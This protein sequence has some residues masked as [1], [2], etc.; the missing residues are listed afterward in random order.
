M[1]K[2]HRA[3]GR[4]DGKAQ[5]FKAERVADSVCGFSHGAFPV[6]V[7]SS[8]QIPGAGA[9]LAE[10]VLTW[11]EHNAMVAPCK[12]GQQGGLV[13]PGAGRYRCGQ[14]ENRRLA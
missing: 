14:S 8:R 13:M 9:K 2:D 4:D 12:G 10:V 7:G 1:I 6:L 5:Q 11:A 3:Q